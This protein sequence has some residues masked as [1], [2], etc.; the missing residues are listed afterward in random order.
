MAVLQSILE[1][2][3]STRDRL[4]AKRAEATTAEEIA[5][6]NNQITVN[7]RTLESVQNAVES[8]ERQV[9]QLEHA[10]AG[11]SSDGKTTSS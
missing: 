5:R 1:T 10:E 11:D 6:L 3:R 8:L 4:A 9:R 2:H 7:T